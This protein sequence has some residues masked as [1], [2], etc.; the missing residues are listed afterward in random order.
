MVLCEDVQ[1]DHQPVHVQASTDFGDTWSYVVPQCLPSDGD[2]FGKEIVQP[3][4]HF[5]S[6]DWRRRTIL[7]PE[8]F[9]ERSRML[10]DL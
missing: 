9:T 3:S 8:R 10:K 4:A 6:R 7:L 1:I 2:C 5:V